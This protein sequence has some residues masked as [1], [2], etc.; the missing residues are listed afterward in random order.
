MGIFDKLREPVILKEESDAKQKLEQLNFCLKTASPDLVPK[1]QQ[2]IRY[3]QYGIRGEDSLM[4]ELK[5][6]H[7]AMYVMHDL[8]FEWNGL[9]TQI[10][11][12]IVTRKLVI[13]IECK[14]L[15]GYISVDSQGNFTRTLQMG[16]KYVKKGIYSPVT[17]NQ[18]HIDMIHELR[19]ETKPSLLRSAFDKRFDEAYKSVIVLANPDSVLDM[20]NAPRDIAKRVVKA[21]S[22]VSHIKTLQDNSS[23]GSM[24][25]K[26]MKELA[27]FFLEKSIPNTMD[28]TEKYRKNASEPSEETAAE[29]T[30]DSEFAQPA[31]N[32]TLSEN[33]AAHSSDTSVKLEDTP[34]YKALKDYRYKKSR[35]EG[36][37]PYFL[38]NN[39]QL[40]NIIHISPATVEELKNVN[41]FGDVKCR[42]YGEDIIRIISEHRS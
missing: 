1:I 37:K 24:S 21:D 9:K 33:E 27:E 3:T 16:T 12:L 38:Y 5:N 8:F 20:K 4:F 42:K 11:Y 18:R 31:Q 19:R 40:E 17:Q 14:N 41:G 29:V 36:V 2:D 32:S 13:V 30:E 28:Y 22:L 39:S 23:A 7:M 34:L 10:D 15:Y 26:E 6:S 25:D 35:E